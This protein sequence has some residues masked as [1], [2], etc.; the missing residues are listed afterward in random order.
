[1][2]KHQKVNHPIELGILTSGLCLL[3]TPL[4]LDKVFIV[5]NFLIFLSFLIIKTKTFLASKNIT[6]K[7]LDSNIDKKISLYYQEKR[8]INL[9]FYSAIR[10][11]ILFFI[12]F[13]FLSIIIF[14]IF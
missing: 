2:E 13:S 3:I 14:L 7:Q 6:I 4:F 8:Y 9:A 11:L 1:M 5:I 10:P 12:I